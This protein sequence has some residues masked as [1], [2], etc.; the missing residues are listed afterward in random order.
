MKKIISYILLIIWLLVIFYLSNQI[1]D[2]S[3]SE[4][5]G[6]IYNILNNIYNLFNIDKTNLINIVQQINNPLRE[7]M[8]MLEYLVLAVLTI[9]VLK[10]SNTKENI[11]IISIM[12]C[13][14]YATSDEIHQLFVPG[15]A[16]EYFDIFMD[17]LGAVIGS[18]IGNK[19][20]KEK[21]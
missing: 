3:G 18:I 9:N 2:V 7:L 10:Q 8:H 14:I 6:I 5:S 16:F 12:F 4:S 21:L 19:I 17:T 1:G 11:I 15:R 13:F 20:I